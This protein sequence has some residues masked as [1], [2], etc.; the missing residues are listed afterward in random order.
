MIFWNRNKVMTTAVTHPS[1]EW[2]QNCLTSVVERELVPKQYHDMA[3]GMLQQLKDISTPDFSTPDLKKSG[4]E[5]SFNCYNARK[6]HGSSILL[7]TFNSR[8]LNPITP[9]GGYIT[10]KSPGLIGLRKIEDYFLYWPGCPKG[11]KLSVYTSCLIPKTRKGEY[12]K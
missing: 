11:S 7:S 6:V 3:V 8:I 12:E 10:S 5:M 1:T 2:V 9:G 4:V